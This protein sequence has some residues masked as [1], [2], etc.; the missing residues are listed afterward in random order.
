MDTIRGAVH[1]PLWV[2]AADIVVF[3]LLFFAQAI[4]MTG[5]FVL[6]PMGVRV[7]FHSEWRVVAW[8]AGVVVIRHLLF[9]RPAI[10]NRLASG[11]REAA[12]A[13]QV[14]SLDELVGEPAATPVTP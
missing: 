7:P 2:R 9:R 3:A 5:G 1:P 13:Q 4:W 12:R 10:H 14:L 11:I 6:H 8:A